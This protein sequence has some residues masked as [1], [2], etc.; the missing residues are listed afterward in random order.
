MTIHFQKLGQGAPLVIIHGLFG[1]SDNLKA[2]AKGLSDEFTVYLIDAPGHG[3]ST[4]LRPLSLEAMAR[5]VYEFTLSQGLERFSILGHSLGGKIAMELSLLHPNS[6]ERLI[7]ADI[8]P[9]H[10]PRRH[11]SIISALK[12]VPLLTLSGRGEADQILAGHINEAGVRGF[13]LKS[14]VRTVNN[15]GWQWKFDLERL[16]NDYEFLVSAN[17]QGNY[18]GRVLFIVGGN[19]NYISPE[20][21]QDIIGR[22]PNA[23]SKLIQGAGHWLHAEKPSAFIKITRDFLS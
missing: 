10:Y 1:T 6:V 21:K 4:S 13:L 5:A 15:E 7:V 14:L 17:R 9:V 19:S 8:A 2:V 18:S 11:D 16:A 22:F 20:H 3:N 23:T 12:S